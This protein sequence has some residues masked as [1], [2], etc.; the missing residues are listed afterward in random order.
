[1][2]YVMKRYVFV[3]AIVC[4]LLSV[5]SVYLDALF[6][7]EVFI[8]SFVLAG[9]FAFYKK[10][11]KGFAV[12]MACISLF[13]LLSINTIT[14]INKVIDADGKKVYI[15]S[16]V[17][18]SNE[19]RETEDTRYCTVKVLKS[20]NDIL[21]RGDK[22]CVYYE[23]FDNYAIGTR[24]D[25]EFKINAIEPDRISFLADGVSCFLSADYMRVTKGD[26][27]LYNF[28][29]KIQSFI[30]E[31][32]LNKTRNS[33]LLIAMLYG[34]R[35]FISERLYDAVKTCGTS[36][37]L[38]VSGLHFTVI[39]GAF[40]KFCNVF[41][42]KQYVKNILLL[43]FMF[44]FSAVCG[45]SVSVTRVMIVYIVVMIYK[46]LGRFQNSLV[47]FCNALFIVLCIQPLAFHSVSFQLSFAATL[48]ILVV[49]PLFSKAIYYRYNK[50]PLLKAL[51]ESAAVTLS[52]CIFTFPTCVYYFGWISLVAIPVNVL[53]GFAVSGMLISSC[54]G[55]ITALIN[56]DF[57]TKTVFFICDAFADYFIK[58]VK[59]FYRLPFATVRFKNTEILV[60]AVLFVYLAVY[61][62]Y[63]CKRRKNL[64]KLKE[65]EIKEE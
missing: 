48:G 20:N 44:C 25:G 53:I 9:F 10:K 65:N 40:I 8:I 60:I 12:C 52:A 42:R 26:I 22:A 39:C 4:L 16:V 45:F 64:I 41:L 14:D 7:I 51:L 55:L 3:T 32:L 33:G 17:I 59:C 11:C 27:F 24:L 23:A 54:I 62:T 50:R 49:Y 34:E 29:E 1:M 35:G 37:I 36:H 56:L 2:L 30:K 47:G 19:Q 21:K 46:G 31:T 61:L 43:I 57:I 18:E 6:Y 13:C 5:Y 58:I 38:V 28:C 15:S 63:T